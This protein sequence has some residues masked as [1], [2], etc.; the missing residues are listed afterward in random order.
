MN[1]LLV[2]DE[3]RVASFMTKG[4]RAQGH[5]VHWCD[6]GH[7]ALE[8]LGDGRHWDLVLLDLGLPDIDG[9]D[10][11]QRIRDSHNAVPVVVVTARHDDAHCNRASELG[12]HRYLTKP[13]TFTDLIDTL[14]PL[15]S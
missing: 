10:V 13:F 5:V 12:V 8:A 15:L 2:E 9:L 11:L 7:P 4:L 3:P 14:Q 6:A 1:L